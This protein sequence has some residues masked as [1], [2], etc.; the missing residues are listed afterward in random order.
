MK[1]IYL[2]ASLVL[3]INVFAQTSCSVTVTYTAPTCPTC[4][5]GSA[6]VQITE[7]CPPYTYTWTP[8][9]ATSGQT[10]TN[11]CAGT[12]S[13]GITDGGGSGCCGTMTGTVTIPSGTA[14]IEQFAN[15]NEQVSIYPNPATNSIQVSFS[16]NIESTT[17]V[18]TDMLGNTIKQMPFTT[19]HNIISVA[20]LA[21]GVYNI[22]IQNDPKGTQDFRINKRVVIVR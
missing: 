19:Q 13:V 7:S 18:I 12:Y 22:S 17:L 20:D 3:T 6:S 21:E 2:L 16:G 5:D 4:C 14:G 1:K 15:T 8:I 9:A 10:I 11:L